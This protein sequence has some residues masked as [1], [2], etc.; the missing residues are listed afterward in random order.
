MTHGVC[1]HCRQLVPAKL[2]S[3]GGKVY[4]RK[5][6]PAHGEAQHL[7]HELRREF[8]QGVRMHRRDYPRRPRSALPEPPRITSMKT[9]LTQLKARPRLLGAA[10]VGVVLTLL[11]PASSHAVT[12]G[13]LGWNAAVWLYL[14][15]VG[16]DMARLDH[17]RLQQRVSAQAEGAVV[18]LAI[19]IVATLASMVAIFAELGAAKAAS[20]ALGWPNVLLALVTL[21]GSWLLL[22]TEFALSY[23][24]LYFT[25]AAG[26]LEFPRPASA[27]GAEPAPNYVDFLYFSITIAATAQTSDVAVTTRAMRQLVL[28]QSV[29]SFAFNALVLALAINMAASLF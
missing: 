16:L 24:S 4:S 28:L 2:V 27:P 9:L 19:A 26:G 6:C 11:L 5:F 22:P 23:A 13:V 17:R 29:L 21:V 15:L 7:V 14:L 8:E 20:G 10:T 18:V 12:R 1:E 25:D 3:D